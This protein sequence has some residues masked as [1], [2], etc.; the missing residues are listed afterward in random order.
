MDVIE[1]TIEK[2]H[3]EKV[4][5]DATTCGHVFEAYI[6]SGLYRTAMEA[7]EVLCVRMILSLE[8][9]KVIEEY[10]KLIYH[11]AE[12]ESDEAERAIVSSLARAKA[13]GKDDNLVF[14]L[15]N[16]RWCAILKGLPINWSSEQS[17]WSQRLSAKYDVGQGFN[18]S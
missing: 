8:E 1:H 7:L 13:D 3:Q 18:I 16:L 11:E 9:E 10:E 5:P 17:W 6:R 12:G 15:L 4:S 14:A 2:M